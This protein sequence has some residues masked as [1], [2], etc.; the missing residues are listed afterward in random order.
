M[1]GMWYKHC[2]KCGNYV[3]K[4]DPQESGVCYA[5]GWVEYVA[6]FYCEVRHRYC[7]EDKDRAAA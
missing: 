6:V 1:N 2:P 4:T 5:C 7:I 3:K